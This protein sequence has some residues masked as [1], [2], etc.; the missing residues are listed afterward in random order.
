MAK[1]Q[2]RDG[3][4]SIPDDIREA[5]HLRDGEEL[6]AEI[7]AAGILLRTPQPIDPNQAWFWTK[8]WQEGEREADEDIK[9]GRG[10]V[11][12]SDEEFLASLEEDALDD[13]DV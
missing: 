1:T 12:Y 8:E 10:R 6:E 5:A 9:A 11:F 2:F 13:A 7:T 3:K 4:I